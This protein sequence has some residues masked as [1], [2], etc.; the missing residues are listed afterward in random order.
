MSSV[1]KPGTPLYT[2]QAMLP[3]IDAFGFE[4]DLRTHTQGQAFSISCFDHW[5]I[6]PGD[7]LDK[8]ILLRPLE[9]APMDALAREFMVKTR[10]RKVK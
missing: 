3:L 4:T 8:S 10:R 6:V 1:P 5:E 2:L 7:P 9:P